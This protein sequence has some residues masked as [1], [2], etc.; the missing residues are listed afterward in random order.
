MTW[1][2][3]IPITESLHFIETMKLH[4]GL[5][6][7]CFYNSEN[8]ITYIT[9][10]RGQMSE[11]IRSICT[12]SLCK[13]YFNAGRGTI[14]MPNA[15]IFTNRLSFVGWLCFCYNINKASLR[16]DRGKLW[17]SVRIFV[18]VCGSSQ[19][20]RFFQRWNS[21]NRDFSYYLLD[22]GLTNIMKKLN[23]FVS[24][25]L[26]PPVLVSGFLILVF[27][28][29]FIIFMYLVWRR[30]N[31]QKKQKKL[32]RKAMVWRHSFSY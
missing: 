27:L 12:K 25:I 8:Y 15:I 19:F 24:G 20:S 16:A 21:F 32:R 31:G 29:I 26:T 2:K 5:R 30:R 17:N 7:S 9:L 11:Y 18:P 3:Q 23:Y 4:R 28:F 22:S 1:P 6:F 13:W 14:T 10:A